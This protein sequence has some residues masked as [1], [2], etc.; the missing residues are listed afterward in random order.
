LLYIHI[1]PDSCFLGGGFHLPEPDQLL[2]LREAIFDNPKTFRKIQD[3][4][5][6][7]GMTFM[8][9]N[10]FKRVPKG[11]EEVEDP[12]LIE[13]LK[14]RSLV[15]VQPLA[16]STIFERSLVD[17]M[18]EFTKQVLPLLKFGWSAIDR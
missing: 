18:I 2:A 13:V 14:L 4:L 11:F 3:K 6:A 16:E 17:H 1:S 10:P 12:A 7:D 15:V 5:L 9:E 8:V